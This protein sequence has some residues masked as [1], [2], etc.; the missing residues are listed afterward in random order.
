[1][2][3]KT[4]LGKIHALRTTTRIPLG[5]NGLQ[6]PHGFHADFDA[7]S[8]CKE[9]LKLYK[10]APDFFSPRTTEFLALEMC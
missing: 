4:V 9:G 2:D 10:I 8:Q 7:E 1:M 3:F 6:I 5:N